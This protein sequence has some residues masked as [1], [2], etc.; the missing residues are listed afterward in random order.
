MGPVIGPRECTKVRTNG[1]TITI[2]VVDGKFIIS[3]DFSPWGVTE[4]T[5]QL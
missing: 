5:V 1:Y 4:L 3:H 2:K